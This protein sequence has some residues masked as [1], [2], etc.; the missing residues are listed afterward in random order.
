MDIFLTKRQKQ[1]THATKKHTEW[2]SAKLSYA[3][4]TNGER[5]VLQLVTDI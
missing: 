5:G 2:R 1:Q 4:R 3:Q